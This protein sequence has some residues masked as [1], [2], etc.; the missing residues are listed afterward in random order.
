MVFLVE[1][2]KFE[3]YFEIEIG[4]VAFFFSPSWLKS[5]EG[6][7]VLRHV[8]SHL[9]SKHNSHLKILKNSAFNLDPI[10]IVIFVYEVRC[11]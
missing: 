10:F 5:Q 7:D 3:R 1:F 8:K 9:R 11:P 6:V 4:A 2:W